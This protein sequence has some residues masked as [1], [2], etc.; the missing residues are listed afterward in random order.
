[1]L[2]TFQHK[3][4]FF[5]ADL[6]QP[7]D[8]SIPLDEAAQVNC[9]YAPLYRTD[10]VIAGDFI[11][12]TNK[13]GPVNFLNIKLNPHGNGTHTECVGLSLIHI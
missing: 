5:Q 10:P 4:A 7:L 13:G 1:M 2:I 12:A 9:F 8:I 3:E 6:S 11:G